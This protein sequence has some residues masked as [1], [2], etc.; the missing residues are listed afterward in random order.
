[1]KVITSV[2]LLGIAACAPL[3]TSPAGAAPHTPAK[4]SSEREAIMNAM[5]RVVGP[6]FR[7][8]VVF[9]PRKLR[10]ERGWAY[11]DGGFQFADGTTVNDVMGDEAQAYAGGNFEAVLH[12]ERGVW[13]VKTSAYPSDVQTPEMMAKFPQAPRALFK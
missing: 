10:V 7:K 9:T 11:F 1:M 3:A 6:N 12:K 2:G 5:R 8:R 13:K 4:G